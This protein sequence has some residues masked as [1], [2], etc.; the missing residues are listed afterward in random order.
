MAVQSEWL[1]K[2]YYDVLGVAESAADKEITSAYRK[3]ARRLHPDAN[4]GDRAA[5]ERFNELS[6]AYE[7]L[8][9]PK[10]RREYDEARQLRRMRG[11]GFTP[12]DGGG[13][14]IR[15][16]TSGDFA[17]FGD[18]GDVEDF[19]AG[20]FTTGGRRRTR[21]PEPQRGPDVEA[22]IQLSFDDAVKGV[23]TTLP[24][25]SD[26]DCAHCAG[27]GARVRRVEDQVTTEPCPNC[28]GRGTEPRSREVKVRVPP[29]VDDGQII[30]LRGHGGAG[31]NGGPAGD[32]LVRVG[33]ASHRLFGRKGADL[34]IEVPVTF[35]EAAL[36]T[37]IK[38]PTLHG[39]PV[40]LRISPGITS[41][42]TFRVRGKG[43]R[44][45]KGAGDLLVRVYVTVPE[46][47]SPE[48]RK[49]VESLAE[50]ATESPRAASGG[51]TVPADNEGVYVI[52]VAAELAGVPP[53]ALRAYER[54]G[55]LSR[56][57]SQ[58]G[59]R[60]DRARRGHCHSRRDLTPLTPAVVGGAI[61]VTP[62][63]P[64]PVRRFPDGSL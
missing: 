58:G 51:V 23:T 3:L 13:F 56:A 11:A 31:R 61:P 54:K 27:S 20:L 43:A 26:V 7:V 16:D 17:D 6:A 50:A 40:T 4:A 24:L 15:V 63:T 29:G 33:V 42:K 22:Q 64:T 18:V 55:S 21:S 19:L 48:E 45:R 35:A 12:S 14:N 39:A 10:K 32:L 44:Q 53:D 37:Q 9:D 28:G 59:I 1:E 36:G 30:R 8:G 25:I 60:R 52:S 38:V 34:T 62:I 46:R 47:L 2:D 5:E 49:L 41:G 57:R